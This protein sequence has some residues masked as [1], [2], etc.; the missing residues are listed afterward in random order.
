MSKKILFFGNERIATGVTTR[1]PTF[2]RL[3]EEGYEI[4]ALVLAQNPQAH[5]RALRETEIVHL[6]EGHNVPIL[7]LQ[8]LSESVDQIRAFN[9]SAAVLVAYGKIVPQSVIDS[10]PRGIIN[11][12]PSL[13]PLHRG[14]TP[15][16]SVM[17][18]GDQVTGVSLMQLSSK[19]DAGPVFAQVKLPLNGRET[20]Q[21]LADELLQQ[22]SRLMIKSLP[23]IL[24]GSLLAEPQKGEPTYDSLIKKNDGI[25]DWS[26]T[27]TDLEREVRAYLS[28]PK[29]SF[30]LGET[31]IVVTESHVEGSDNAWIQTKG[32]SQNNQSNQGKT[33]LIVEI[34]PRTLG[35]QTAKD[36]LM[37]DRLIPSGRK[38]MS[39]DAFLSGY[40]P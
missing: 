19:M 32:W 21:A 12:H 28:W 13:L 22:G 25:L 37:I 24:D 14:S 9:A 15:L 7:Y 5:S 11:L 35:F 38:E 27:A 40:R 17:L 8:K 16:E 18:E 10:F 31:K 6:A 26:K 23:H 39:V 30:M 29:S 2:L 33:G 34:N 4:A 1:A 3:I 36:I 20:K